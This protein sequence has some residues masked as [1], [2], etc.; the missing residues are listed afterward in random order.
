MWGGRALGGSRAA[1]VAL[2]ALLVALIA[3]PAAH[4]QFGVDEEDWIAQM[5]GSDAEVFDVATQT[6]GEDGIF[7]QAGGHG[8]KGITDFT[9]RLDGDTPAGGNAANVRVDVPAGLVPNP[10]IFPRCPR[11]VFDSDPSLCPADTQI[12]IEELEIKEGPVIARVRVPL[13]NVGINPDEVSLFGFHPADAAPLVPLIGSLEGLDPVYIVGGVRDQPSIF[14]PHDVGLYFT[15]DDA[16]ESPTVLSSKLTFWGVPGDPVHNAQRKQACAT[17][18]T[19]STAETC[20]PPVTNVPSTVPHLPF[21]NNPTRCTGIPLLTRLS[22]WSHS[23]PQ[24]FATVVGRTPTIDGNDGAR[25]CE[26]V[27]FDQGIEVTPDTTQPDA[28]VGP[29]VRLSTPQQG[30]HDKDVLTTSHVKDVTVT[31]PPG[32]TINPSAANGLVACTDA[33]L[34]ANTG[35]VGGDECPEASKV[36]TVDVKSPLLPDSL[37]GSAFV[38]Q[39]LAGDRYRLFVTV[40]GRGVSVRLKGSVRPNP[41]TGQL[42]A[43][44]PNNPEQPVDTFDVD[45]NNGS[46]AP[47]ATPQ[48]CGPK[49]A[50]GTFT[51]WSGTAPVTATSGFGIGGAGCPPGFEP[52]FG[53]RTANPVSGAFAPFGAS[54]ARADRNQFLSG[55]RV[56]TPPGLGAMIKGVEQCSDAAAATGACPASS[57]I[58]TASTRS[59]AGPEPF[60]LAGPVYFTGRYRDAPFGMVVAIRAIAGPYDLGTVVVRQRV[61]VDP[62]DAHVTV[63]SDPLPR[64]LAGV[65]IRL[66]DIDVAIDRDRFVYNPT[67]CGAKQVGATLHSV[68]GTARQRAAGVRFDNCEALRFEPRMTMRMTGPRQ[69]A[70]GRH[71]G[72]RVRVT[73]PGRQAGIGNARVTL[74]LSLALDP[75]NAREICGFEAGLRADCPARS[76]IGRATAISP[77]LN[78]P[79]KGP[80]YFV[81]GIRIDPTTGNRIRTLPSLLVKLN[82]E[83]RINLR[84]DTAVERRKLVSTFES[85]PDAPVS[86]FDMRLRGGKGGILAVA[87]RRGLCA[88]R[89][90]VAL[91]AFTGQNGKRAP[92]RVRMANPCKRAGLKIGKVRA[93]GNR[94]AVIGRIAKGARK[95][96][97]VVLRCAKTRVVKRAKRTGPRRWRTAL[98][99]RGRCAGARRAKLRVV[100]PGGGRFANTVRKRN[101]RLPG[102]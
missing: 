101:V 30:L 24:E 3:A 49:T 34:A 40:E 74:P 29:R 84:G 91:A 32:M 73:Q 93:R 70:L 57:R 44:F 59:G 77:A 27:P 26:R 28:P 14:G 76:R 4:A 99:R 10:T 72:L 6:Y 48:D 68:A 15:I 61:Y 50:S 54:I 5:F 60:A 80:V 78:R 69:T 85:I 11:A 22:L 65:P 83:V 39:P 102:A 25:F 90:H 42:T 17:G 86:R 62:N 88:R 38:G 94:V 7:D 55:V 23:D 1:Y 89:R 66:R 19:P 53:A 12:G 46:R 98:P 2:I 71:P 97:R 87:A 33:Q 9:M 81:Q 41:S 100:Y 79:L 37:G 35:T 56:D 18:I 64:I 63:V 47:L 75:E 13:Y 95:R 92:L 52:G 31:L 43:V 58:G 20:L 96:V 16:P 21:L 8:W 45:F 51:P 36:G 82:G 67:S